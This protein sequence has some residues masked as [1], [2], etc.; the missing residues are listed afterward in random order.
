ML[1]I[2]TISIAPK[3]PLEVIISI[4]SPFYVFSKI[5][6]FKLIRLRTSVNFLVRKQDFH[7]NFL[8][9]LEERHAV[10]QRVP[11][12]LFHEDFKLFAHIYDKTRLE[13]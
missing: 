12:R 8:E 2:S 7:S 11:L 5:L 4:A 10:L 3:V 1:I 13:L 9:A 6:E